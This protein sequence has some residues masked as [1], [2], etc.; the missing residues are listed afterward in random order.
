MA[1]A[2]YA[3][4]LKISLNVLIRFYQC[5]LKPYLSPCCRFHP[6]CSTYA[7]EVLKTHSV[8]K[9]IWLISKRLLRCQP[10]AKGGV[11]L[12]P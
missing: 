9:S 6:S 1:E 12:V 7:L 10:F 5:C 8:G 11:D 3:R 2:W 4:G